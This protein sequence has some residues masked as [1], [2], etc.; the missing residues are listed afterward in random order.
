MSQLEVAIHNAA[1]VSRELEA[2]RSET[3]AA[4]LAA[5]AVAADKSRAEEML[6]QQVQEHGKL[7]EVSGFFS[8]SSVQIVAS[9]KYG[10]SAGIVER[11]TKDLQLHGPQSVR[12]AA[13]CQCR[14]VCAAVFEM[15]VP[16]Y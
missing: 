13:A 7:T 14:H 1:Q 2:S 10:K 16:S 5:D 8:N 6:A 11:A 12:H 15:L 9:E 4:K 3:Q